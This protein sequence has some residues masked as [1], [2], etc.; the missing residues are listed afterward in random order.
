M[1]FRQSLVTAGLCGILAIGAVN[2]TGCTSG[3][4]SFRATQTDLYY[5]QLED[6]VYNLID[7]FSREIPEGF[8]KVEGKDSYHD[9]SLQVPVGQNA[10]EE[11]ASGAGRFVTKSSELINAGYLD[12]EEV[13][14][15]KRAGDARH[16]K[17]VSSFTKQLNVRSASF[18]FVD[19]I[20]SFMEGNEGVVY[21][22]IDNIW[23]RKNLTLGS[24]KENYF[25][26]LNSVRA[27][28]SVPKEQA[29]RYLD[30]AKRLDEIYFK[31]KY[32]G[33]PE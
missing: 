12:A 8:V 33:R 16:L 19:D 4:N 22:K 13:K 23:R 20:L 3:T 25:G 6:R 14:E 5:S 29:E 2:L 28:P 31:G 26:D 27:L 10:K 32:L 21:I 9:S 24:L 30:L 7:S 18:G 1:R 11:D 15:M 17:K